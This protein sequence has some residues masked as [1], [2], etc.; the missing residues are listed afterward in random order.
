[1]VNGPGSGGADDASFDEQASIQAFIDELRVVGSTFEWFRRGCFGDV[2]S[3][4]GLVSI[5][6]TLSGHGS[7]FGSLRSGWVGLLRNPN[8]SGEALSCP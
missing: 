7:V 6:Q 1:M 8:V 4:G 5:R 3:F 2:W